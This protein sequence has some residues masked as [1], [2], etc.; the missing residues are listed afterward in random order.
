MAP[1]IEVDAATYRSLELAARLTG[2][3]V[4]GVVS[5][6]V[7]QAVEGPA[8]DSPTPGVRPDKVSIYADYAGTRTHGEFESSSSQ[9]QITTGP[10]AGT[11][12]GTPSQA[13]V[14]VVQHY[15]PDVDPNR[16]GWTFWVLDDGSGARIQS[17]R[18]R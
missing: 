7:A 9:I 4:G 14:A 17:I 11:T 5:R 18:Q 12:Y 6:L 15:K 13:A 1:S 2:V 16:N 8:R 3:S 10:L